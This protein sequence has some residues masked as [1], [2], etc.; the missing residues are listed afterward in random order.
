MIM[1]KAR[2]WIIL[3]AVVLAVCIICACHY[4]VHLFST[5]FMPFYRCFSVLSPDGKQIAAVECEDQGALGGRTFV[6]IRERTYS[7]SNPSTKGGKK[8]IDCGF[9]YPDEIEIRWIDNDT[10]E[11]NK[12]A[13]EID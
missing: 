12:K 3:V 7:D 11:F 9:L 13:Y 4:C 2:K 1:R 5:N 6:Y 10:L 8:I